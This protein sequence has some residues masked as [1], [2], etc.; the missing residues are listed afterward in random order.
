M[1]SVLKDC[2]LMRK[3]GPEETTEET[4]RVLAHWACFSKKGIAGNTWVLD[5]Q[6]VYFTGRSPERCD[7]CQQR[8]EIENQD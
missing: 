3:V 1:A 7:I 4:T 5:A 2:V 6:P 8:F